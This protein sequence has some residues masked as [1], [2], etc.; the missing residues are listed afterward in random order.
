MNQGVEMEVALLTVGFLPVMQKTLVRSLGWE[1]PLEKGIATHS[2]I[3]AC[4]EAGGVPCLNPRR[5]LT[6]LSPVCRDP[7][8]GV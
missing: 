5:G 7:A 2:S 6:L 1:D 4:R 3:L 8:I